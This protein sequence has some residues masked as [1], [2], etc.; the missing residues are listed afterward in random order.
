MLLYTF[1]LDLI[2]HPFCFYKLALQAEKISKRALPAIQI[3][4]HWSIINNLATFQVLKKDICKVKDYVLALETSLKLLIWCCMRI[5]GDIMGIKYQVDGNLDFFTS[6]I[7][8]SK[9][10]HFH[11]LPFM[12]RWIGTNGWGVSKTRMHWRSHH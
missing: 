5:F 7:G 11:Q 12:H 4:K 1:L 6:N 8:L 2:M 3:S 10:A 9:D